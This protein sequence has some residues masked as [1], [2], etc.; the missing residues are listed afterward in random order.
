MLSLGFIYGLP[1]RQA[2]FSWLQKGRNVSRPHILQQKIV[3]PSWDIPRK[4]H[5]ISLPLTGHVHVL[6]PYSASKGMWLMHWLPQI[7]FTCF[8]IEAYPPG[9][10]RVL[11]NNK[12]RELGRGGFPEGSEGMDGK[13][14]RIDFRRSRQ[15]GWLCITGYARIGSLRMSWGRLWCLFRVVVAMMMIFCARHCPVPFTHTELIFYMYPAQSPA[16]PTLTTQ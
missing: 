16:G 3:C 13:E 4:S 9:G 15:K 7:L 8:T 12:E 14:S 6:G 11:S 1:P 5:R 2:F 10:G